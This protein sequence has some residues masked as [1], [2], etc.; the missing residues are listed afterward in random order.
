MRRLSKMSNKVK[1][2]TRKF[3]NKWNYKIS[4]LQKGVTSLRY[5]TP[6]EAADEAEHPELKSICLSLSTLDHTSYCK[7]IENHILDI[8]TNDKSIF[9]MLY[10]K[11]IGIIRS[12]VA[13]AEGIE[14][15]LSDSHSVVVKKLPHNRYK[16]KVYLQPHKIA[17]AQEKNRFINWLATQEPRVNITETVK[18]WFYKTQ[19]NWDRR[20]MYVEDDQTLLLL[21]LKNSDALGTVYTFRVSDK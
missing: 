10:Q 11:H 17:D 5:R 16:Y 14:D 3:Y 7:R 4:M 8:Y 15:L 13:P 18:Q 1:Q 9:D 12:A 20:Y 19:W 2:T 21:K 6:A